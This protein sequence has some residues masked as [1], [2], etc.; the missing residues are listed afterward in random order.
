MSASLHMNNFF[1]GENLGDSH[2]VEKAFV[3]CLSCCNSPKAFAVKSVSYYYGS[4]TVTF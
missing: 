1:E 3:D 4:Q 2:Y